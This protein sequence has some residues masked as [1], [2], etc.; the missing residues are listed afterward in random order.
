MRIHENQSETLVVLFFIPK[1]KERTHM[2]K[3][4]SENWALLSFVI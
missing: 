2:I 1:N 3:F 4:L